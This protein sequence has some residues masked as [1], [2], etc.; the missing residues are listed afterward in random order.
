[1]LPDCPVAE[2]TP[3][4]NAQD[5]TYKTPPTKLVCSRNG[6]PRPSENQQISLEVLKRYCFQ[7]ARLNLMYIII[8]MQEMLLKLE[9]VLIARNKA[10][11]ETAEHYLKVRQTLLECGVTFEICIKSTVRSMF[12]VIYYYL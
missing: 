10:I 3:N 1:M 6:D 5:E 4:G 2:T 7:H 11:Q 9:P 12:L 8:T